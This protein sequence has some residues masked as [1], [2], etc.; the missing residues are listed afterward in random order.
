MVL[1]LSLFCVEN[2]VCLSRGVQVTGVT[3]R[4][5]TRI[6]AGVGDL[7][8]RIRE[9]QAQVRYSVARRLRG[10]DDTVC[11]LHRAQVDEEHKFL[12]LASKSRSTACQW[13]GLKTT[14]TGFPVW[15]SKPVAAVW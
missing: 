4:T 12:G 11:G 8:Q 1:P 3:W 9:D 5:V 7:I 2:Q 15:A 6:M 10:W 13:F 14:R